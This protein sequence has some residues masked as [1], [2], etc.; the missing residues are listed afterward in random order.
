MGRHSGVELWGSGE[1][2]PASYSFSYF[3]G[4]SPPSYS[5]QILIFLGF[6]VRLKCGHFSS[7]CFHYNFA[8][9]Y[10]SFTLLS[11]RTLSKWK[12]A[13]FWFE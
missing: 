5:Q 12:I 1:L 13:S 4:L 8:F 6:L 3:G 9:F 10:A 2:S 11:L 7:V